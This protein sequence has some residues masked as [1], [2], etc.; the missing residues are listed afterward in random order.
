M[1]IQKNCR[2]KIV[3]PSEFTIDSNLNFLEGSGFFMSAGPIRFEVYP[4]KNTLIVS[5]CEQNFGS[6]T[7][8]VL[9][10]SRVLNQE[11]VHKTGSF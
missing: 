5:A 11:Y 6:F 10:V 9:T 1:P 3:Y 2:I 8:G 7:N 4:D